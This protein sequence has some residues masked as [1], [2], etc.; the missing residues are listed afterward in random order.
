MTDNPRAVVIGY[1]Y[2][3]RCF[4]SY[5]IDITPSLELYGVVSSS[6]EKRE[7][8]ERDRGCR[9][10]GNMDDVLA[11]PAVDLVVLATPN[12]VHCPQAVRALEAGKHVVTDKPMCLNLEECDRM[13]AAAQRN[14]RI[15][16]V[17]QNRR[18][19][20]DYLTVRKLID[21]GRLGDVRWMEMAWQ[22][23]GPNG[24]WRGQADKGGGGL[25]DL[26]AHMIDQ[27]LQIFPAPVETVY[28]RMHHDFEE[29]DV[30][31]EAL[32]VLTFADGRT[33]VVDTS[34][35][36]AIRKPRFYVRGTRGSFR[37]YGLDPQ[38]G[39]MCREDIDGAR[40]EPAAC[41]VFSDGRNEDPV[42]TLP[43]RWRCYYENIASAI[44]GDEEV[45][46]KPQE[47]R[48]VMAVF[49]AAFE[50]ARTKQVVWLEV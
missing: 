27:A 28:C 6:P 44:R 17:F 30:E 13:I 10:F 38:E 29:V 20:G 33:V 22:G 49:E 34:R 32:T 3:G 21:E 19:D 43:G 8:V 14:G 25:F 7:A 1:G 5:L 50:S 45:L 11:D 4:H 41:G 9:A 18:W 39:A 12:H 42:P 36:A 24:R 46:V 40:E 37:K 35:L 2:A 31:S 15:L 48:R 47:T 23:F 16:S 26:G